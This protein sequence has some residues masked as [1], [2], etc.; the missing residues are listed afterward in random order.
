MKLF[1]IVSTIDYE[2]YQQFH[3]AF[4]TREKAEEIAKSISQ[5]EILEVELDQLWED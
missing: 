4:S 1:V 2:T 3:G 5:S